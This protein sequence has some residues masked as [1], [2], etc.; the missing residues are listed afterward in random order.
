MAL[1]PIDETHALQIQAGIAGRKTGHEFEDQICAELNALKFPYGVPEMKPGHVFVGDPATLLLGYIA[2]QFRLAQLS[3]VT[4][5]STG[6]LA[7]S[8]EGRRWLSINGASVSRCKSDLVMTLSFG[9][10]Q[11]HTV[12]VSTKQCSN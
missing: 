11:K 6:A 9:R 8:E 12:G 10:G 5:I 3:A 4:A 1:T 7:T 2:S